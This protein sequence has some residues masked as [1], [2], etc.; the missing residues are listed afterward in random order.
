M[1]TRGDTCSDSC[2]KLNMFNRAIKWSQVTKWRSSRRPVAAMIALCIH[3][4]TWQPDDLLF[5]SAFAVETMTNCLKSTMCLR[6]VHIAA[7]LRP[8][9][10]GQC[11]ANILNSLQCAGCNNQWKISMIFRKLLS[12]LNVLLASH[13]MSGIWLLL[14]KMK[15]YAQLFYGGNNDLARTMFVSKE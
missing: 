11:L 4:V 10:L 13:A 2:S 15:Q 5:H 9:E 1:Y 8:L 14:T 7:P 12:M 6:L 3:Y